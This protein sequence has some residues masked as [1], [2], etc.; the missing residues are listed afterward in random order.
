MDTGWKSPTSSGATFNQWTNGGN[1]FANDGQYAEATEGNKYQSYEVFNFGIPVRAVIRGI[2][3]RCDA[4]ASPETADLLIAII[5]TS[6]DDAGAKEE[7][8]ETEEQYHA[9]GSSTDLWGKTPWLVTD[10]S[11]DNF[12]I[13]LITNDSERSYYLDHIQIKVYYTITSPLPTYFNP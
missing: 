11:N 12:S 7:T 1:A 5:R 6:G 2:E 10:F 13:W 4:K 9:L 8:W 3:V